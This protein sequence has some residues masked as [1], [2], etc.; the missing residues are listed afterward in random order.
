MTKLELNNKIAECLGRRPPTLSTG[1]TERKELF[2]AINSE[3]ALGL[4]PRLSKPRLARSIA[5]IGGQRWDPSCESRGS[6][7]TRLG[8]IKVLAAVAYLTNKH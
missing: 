6:T 1:G 2:L 8:L 7:I 4:D 5:E 3:L